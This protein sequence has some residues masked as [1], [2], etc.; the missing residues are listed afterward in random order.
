E[1]SFIGSSQSRHRKFMPQH[2]I[3]AARRVLVGGGRYACV[4][5]R[6]RWRSGAEQLIRK[7][8]WRGC[9]FLRDDAEFRATRFLFHLPCA[10]GIGQVRTSSLMFGQESRGLGGDS[11]H[12]QNKERRD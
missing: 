1:C 8:A 3:T 6:R 4:S 10:D 2:F 7:Q 5:T 12:D 9:G 11:A